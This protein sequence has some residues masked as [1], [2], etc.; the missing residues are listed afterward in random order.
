MVTFRQD[1][2]KFQVIPQSPAQRLEFGNRLFFTS[3]T[4]GVPILDLETAILAGSLFNSGLLPPALLFHAECVALLSKNEEPF[5]EAQFRRK[6]D[7]GFV[8]GIKE[9]NVHLE[10]WGRVKNFGRTILDLA[11]PNA[12]EVDTDASTQPWT[13]IASTRFE[14]KDITT[15]G[16]AGTSLRISSDF[17]DHPMYLL[18]H[19]IRHL[20]NGQPNLLRRITFR[21]EFRTIFTFQDKVQGD[22]TPI[23]STDWDVRYD[24]IVNYT[25]N[26][27]TRSVT[28]LNA[29]HI[30]PRGG[31]PANV[32]ATDREIM[33]IAKR[34]NPFNTPPVLQARISG[35][36][37]AQVA[38]DKQTDDVNDDF[39]PTFFK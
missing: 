14:I 25:D 22:F 37:A 27:A 30:F 1:G 3:L 4:G 34:G 11:M 2:H 24:Q 39:D 15:V 9:S 38:R 36:S 6:F 26:G 18:P 12:F 21:R 5:Q 28:D 31:N 7:F 32:N 13:R 20:N 8:Q 35:Q 17:D 23:S 16:S 10:Y 29:G 33:G 19:T